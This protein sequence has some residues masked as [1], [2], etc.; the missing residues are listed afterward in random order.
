MVSFQ[1]DLGQVP[2]SWK[3]TLGVECEDTADSNGGGDS[4]RGGRGGRG[5]G[6]IQSKE[7]SEVG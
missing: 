7:S 5:G 6:D 4:G 3:G 2:A 1:T